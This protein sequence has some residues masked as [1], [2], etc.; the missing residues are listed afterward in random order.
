MVIVSGLDGTNGN[1]VP[2]GCSVPLRNIGSGVALIQGI[3]LHIGDLGWGGEM[4]SA[5][6]APNEWTRFAFT[7][8]KDTPALDTVLSDLRSGT[9]TM[10]VRYTDI[11]GSQ[12]FR[13]RVDIHDTGQHWT[14]RQV[15]LY[16]GDTDDEPF[17]ATGPTDD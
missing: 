14:V 2:I 15:F 11:T 8:P 5:V 9:A 7:I 12:V 6:V 10:W 13:T 16:R 3:S 17:A 4:T 1:E